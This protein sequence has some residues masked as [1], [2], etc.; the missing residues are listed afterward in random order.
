MSHLNPYRNP[1]GIV[2]SSR[3]LNTL[4]AEARPRSLCRALLFGPDWNLPSGNDVLGE[5]VGN[6]RSPVTRPRPRPRSERR[7]ARSPQRRASLFGSPSPS[8]PL[9]IWDQIE[10]KG[11]DRH[12]EVPHLSR[13][14]LS[15]AALARDSVGFRRRNLEPRRWF[16][17]RIGT[18]IPLACSGSRSAE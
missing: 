8:P 2:G 3:E 9:P 5:A 18:L 13:S 4:V 6:G 1:F 10:S 14:T 16:P 17:L 7:E 12:D 11:G 15:D